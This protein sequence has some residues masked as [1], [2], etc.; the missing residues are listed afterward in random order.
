MA[1][2]GLNQSKNIALLSL[3]FF[4][5]SADSEGGGEVAL[6]G[7]VSNTRYFMFARQGYR[8]RTW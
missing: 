3:R 1:G 6:E 8:S 2:N 4:Q 5:V 7:E